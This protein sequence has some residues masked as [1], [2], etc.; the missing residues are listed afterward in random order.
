[1][2]NV[3][4]SEEWGKAF[5]PKRLRPDLRSYL[6]KAG[7][8]EV[9]YATFG[10]FFYLSLLA[11]FIIYFWKINPLFYNEN[12]LVKI[13]L[14][15]GGTWFI[16]P[17]LFSV[18]LGLAYYFY[19]DMKVYNRT[20][21]MEEVL[22][23]FLRF[24]SE[25]LK[26]GMSFEKALWSSIKPEFG[27]LA[28]EVRLA[29][30][31]VMTGQDVEDALDEFTTK[32]D[33]PI[34]RRAFKLIVEGMKGGGQIAD[35]IDRIIEDI[36]ETRELKAEMRATNLTYIIFVSFVVLVVAPG[37]FTLSFQFL[38]VLQGLGSKLGSANVAGAPSF[39]ISFGKVAIN[40]EDFKTFSQLALGTIAIF[41]SMIVSIISKGSIKAGIRLIPVFLISS[42][43]AYRVFMAVASSL[44]SGIF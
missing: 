2:V 11:T 14:I 38:V 35:I 27:V 21:R 33:S 16:L 28:S 23:D 1:M 39:L 7:I 42:I 4:F 10:A 6:L 25:N 9:P 3:P 8:T 13:F 40:T 20:K 12:S 29:A 22:P 26:G 5:V 18:G 44:F 37:L 24:V 15:S 17:I 34:L 43:V 19:L 36:E 30:K 31:K 32:Y 41:A